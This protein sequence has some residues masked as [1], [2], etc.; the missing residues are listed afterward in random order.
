MGRLILKLNDCTMDLQF[1][2]FYIT[3][4]QGTKK[5]WF[6]LCHIPCWLAQKEGQLSK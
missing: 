3:I 5:A 6:L 1:S 4:K 2:T